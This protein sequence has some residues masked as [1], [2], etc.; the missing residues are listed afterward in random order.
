MMTVLIAKEFKEALR[1]RWMLGF[2]AAFCLLSLGVAWSGRLGLSIGG[3]S[4]FGRTAA[5][6]VNLILLIVPLL[7]IST[8]ALSITSEREQGT[9]EMLLALPL[10]SS[11]IFWAKAAALAAALTLA[12]GAAFGLVG[13][14]L[15]A[16]GGSADIALFAG[17]FAATWLLAM[18]SL[19]VGFLISAYAGRTILAVG[20]TLMVWFLLVFAG[21]LGL[22]GASLATRLAPGILLA[23]TWLNPLSLYR[24]MAVEALGAPLE[25]L[26]PAGACAQ[27]YLGLFLI[28]ALLMGLA[29]WIGAAL[30]AA[31]RLYQRNPLRQ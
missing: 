20:L 4:G 14:M 2:V 24:L 12:L 18:A 6:L 9:L 10:R 31:Y 11:Q 3:Y 27:D 25:M 7:G 22:L 17:S 23:G 16:R 5:A 19:A 28:P 30:I 26:G 21:D 1:S 29:V 13:A 15:A 8:G